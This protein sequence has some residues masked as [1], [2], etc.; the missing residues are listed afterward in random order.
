MR[1]RDLIDVSYQRVEE[2][3]DG[4]VAVYELKSTGTH[5]IDNIRGSVRLVDASGEYRTGFS[6]TDWVDGSPWLAFDKTRLVYVPLHGEEG[7]AES[8]DA[9][10]GSFRL[11]ISIRELRFVLR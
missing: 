10:P 1:A 11:E 7:L 4:P 9:D 2:G 6:L 5:G 3:R 8:F